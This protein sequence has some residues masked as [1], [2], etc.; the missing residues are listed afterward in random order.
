MIYFGIG[1]ALIVCA[2]I[3]LRY[4]KEKKI[5]KTDKVQFGLSV[6]I[7][8]LLVTAYMIR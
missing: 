5:T 6:V 2:I 1:Y 8:I 7:I 4:Y 3:L